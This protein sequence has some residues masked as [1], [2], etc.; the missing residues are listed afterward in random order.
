MS[1][2]NIVLVIVE[3]N[4]DERLLNSILGKID[5]S[6]ANTQYEVINGDAFTRRNRLNGRN[7]IREIVISFV[8][9]SKIPAKNIALV[10]YLVDIDGIFL[11]NSCLC[12]DEGQDDSFFQYD[13]QQEKVI[14]GSESKKEDVLARWNR[15]LERLSQVWYD[16]FH[17]SLK[18]HSGTTKKKDIP[19]R[20]YFNNLTLEHALV[21]MILRG[22]DATDL[23]MDLVSEFVRQL[24]Q[25][26]DLVEAAIS[27]FK[28]LIPN[29]AISNEEAWKNQKEN[30]WTR[31]STIYFLIEDCKKILLNGNES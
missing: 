23:K 14:F 3:G 25:K 8:T 16:D 19:V 27:F 15:K 18:E 11:D 31:G 20:V 21:N 26:D 28:D 4:S 22:E 7:T 2:K 30:P 6:N 9:K 13:S 12:C 5:T 29:Q 17:I 24:E 10:E 1:N